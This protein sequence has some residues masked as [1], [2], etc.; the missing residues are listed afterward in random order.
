MGHLYNRVNDKGDTM[1][2]FLRGF[3]DVWR[4]L[5]F[6]KNSYRV[7]HGWEDPPLFAIG[8]LIAIISMIAIVIVTVGLLASLL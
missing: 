6:K 1:R 4:V 3:A 7:D 2:N 8:N 5:V